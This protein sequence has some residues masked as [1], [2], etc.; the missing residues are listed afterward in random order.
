M[1]LSELEEVSHFRDYLKISA[2]RADFLIEI[3]KLLPKAKIAI[4]KGGK[5]A[6]FN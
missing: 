4:L 3:L 1:G 6:I 2:F 5:M